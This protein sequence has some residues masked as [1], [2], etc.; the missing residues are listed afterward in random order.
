MPETGPVTLIVYNILGARVRR[1]IDGVQ[2]AGLH[3]VSW[4]GRDDTGRTLG[5][6]VYF[7]R[8]QARGAVRVQ[9]LTVVR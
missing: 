3:Q 9:R 4:E 2:S 1:L 5:P 6:G 7:V 8:M